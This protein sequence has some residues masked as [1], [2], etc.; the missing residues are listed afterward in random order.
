MLPCLFSLSAWA[1]TNHLSIP[2]SPGIAEEAASCQRIQSAVVP[3]FENRQAELLPLYRATQSPKLL[4]IYQ[5]ADDELLQQLR[6]GSISFQESC[7]DLGSDLA[8]LYAQTFPVELELSTIEIRH[9]QARIQS[10]FAALGELLVCE[11]AIRT[12]RAWREYCSNEPAEDD[13]PLCLENLYP[14]TQ[15]VAAALA[16]GATQLQAVDTADLNTAA[17]VELSPQAP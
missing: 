9:A 8:P 4:Q 13:R 1:G 17:L 16:H 10:L 5:R 14:E 15:S 2:C 3:H 11:S 7:S 6:A 12:S